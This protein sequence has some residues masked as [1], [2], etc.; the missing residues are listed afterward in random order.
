M[1]DIKRNKYKL[2]EGT[3]H[4]RDYGVIVPFGPLEFDIEEMKDYILSDEGRRVIEREHWVDPNIP[5]NW[6]KLPRKCFFDAYYNVKE[7]FYNNLTSLGIDTGVP[8]M[9]HGWINIFEKGDRIHWH[10]HTRTEEKNFYHGV[11]CITDGGGSY[12]EYR[13]H[14]TKEELYKIPSQVR[15]GHFI[16]DMLTEHR[17]S[18]NESDEPRITIAFDIIPHYDYIGQ[19]DCANAKHFIPFC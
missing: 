5:Y 13:H 15:Y 10:S 11:I 16:G 12:T 2:A 8:H 17:S 6:A 3:E 18:I 4:E 14:E 1:V 7:A 19:W 9:F